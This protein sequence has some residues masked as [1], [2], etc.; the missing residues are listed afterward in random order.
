MTE[1]AILLEVADGIAVLTLNRP[2]KLNAFAGDMREQLIARLDQVAARRDV[3]VLVITGAGRAF[4]AGGDLQIMIDRQREGAGFEDIEPLLAA[5]EAIVQRLAEIPYPVI[6]AVN[7]VAAGAG[8][9]LA[10]AC[11]TRVASDAARFAESFVKIALHPDWGGSH[12]L[13]RLVGLA[14]ALDLCW[15]GDAIDAADAL[16]QGLVQRVWP[17]GD[18]A[19]TW[20][21]YAE[22][23]AASPQSSVR[24]IKATLRASLGRSLSECLAAERAAQRICWTSPDAAEGLRA[25]AE[26]RPPRFAR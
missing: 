17:D 8:L 23:L 20:R 25:M 5:G 22:R 7:G 13:P 21:A 4:C 19:A 1:A 3:R 15:T 10:L 24:A 26:K 18:F 6:A 2:A 12:A 16:R 14:N 11:D 9:N